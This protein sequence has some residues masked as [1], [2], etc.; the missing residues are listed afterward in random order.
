M[1]DTVIAAIVGAIAGIVTGSIGSLFAPWANWG[2]EKRRKRLEYRKDL[3]KGWRE[4][5]AHTT[6]AYNHRVP[7]DDSTWTEILERDHRFYSLKPHVHSE[8]LER[9]GTANDT[10]ASKLMTTLNETEAALVKSGFKP[11]VTIGARRNLVDEIARLEK[12][13]GL[14]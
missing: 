5:I 3:I 12:E 8:V 9:L 10:Q 4:L 7:E 11:Q 1:S 2:I 13:W 14:I 6:F